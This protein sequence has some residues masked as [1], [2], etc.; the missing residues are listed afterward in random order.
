MNKI[1]VPLDRPKL[2]INNKREAFKKTRSERSINL[3]SM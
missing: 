3:P 2:A 1:Y